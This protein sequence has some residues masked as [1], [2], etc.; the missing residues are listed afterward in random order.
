MLTLKHILMP[1][2]FSQR[3][4]SAAQHAAALA[5]HFHSE[6]TLLHASPPAHLSHSDL[7]KPGIVVEEA[8]A[9]RKEEVRRLLDSFLANELRDIPT[10]RLLMEGDPAERIVEC[11]QTENFDLIMM[12]T[13]GLGTFRRFILG[14]VTAK[15][16][17]DVHCPVWTG[18]HVT[19]SDEIP[20]GPLRSVVCAVDLARGETRHLRWATQFAAQMEADLVVVHAMPSF[21]F[22]P[23]TVYLETELVKTMTSEAKQKILEMLA[24]CKSA[25]IRIQQ[26]IAGG[27]VSKVVRTAVEMHQAGLVVIAR[28]THRGI[29]G[30]L[31]TN[32]YAII[33]D[34][35]CPVISV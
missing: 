26:L 6:V 31:R 30:R 23:E 32:S 27:D 14:S 11:A 8:L 10:R 35:P 9:G 7:E 2:D 21:E 3:C 25:E 24:D 5:S 33:R 13:H 28:S 1:V 16:L 4:V 22:T 15:V 34:S 18:A 29:L 19:E 20:V 12:P 17:H